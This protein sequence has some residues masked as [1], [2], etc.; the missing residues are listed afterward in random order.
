MLQP[1]AFRN[2]LQASIQKMLQ[3]SAC[4]GKYCRWRPT[5]FK[6]D[7]WVLIRP[8]RMDALWYAVYSEDLLTEHFAINFLM[9]AGVKGEI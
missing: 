4:F 5:G 2:I 3:V 8:S 1:R 6:D 9:R 7:S